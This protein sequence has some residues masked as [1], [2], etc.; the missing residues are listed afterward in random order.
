MAAKSWFS[1]RTNESS[2]VVYLVS[3]DDISVVNSVAVG[4][5]GNPVVKALTW[6]ELHELTGCNIPAG[7]NT[8]S[9]ANGN[10][11]ITKVRKPDIVLWPL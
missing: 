9:M 8:I 10:F 7:Q 4:I 3:A 2:I 11:M 6:Q 1:I 5:S